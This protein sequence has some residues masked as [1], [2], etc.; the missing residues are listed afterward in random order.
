MTEDDIK[1]TWL[2]EQKKLKSQ[3]TSLLNES[4]IEPEPDDENNEDDD[5]K[6]G[7]TE[8]GDNSGDSNELHEHSDNQFGGSEV[9]AEPEKNS[10]TLDQFYIDQKQTSELDDSTETRVQTDIP[11]ITANGEPEV[12]PSNSNPEESEEL[13][14]S[15]PIDDNAQYESDTVSP[16]ELQPEQELGPQENIEPQDN[17]ESSMNQTTELIQEK[18]VEPEYDQIPEHSSEFVETSDQSDSAIEAT[19]VEGAEGASDVTD[20]QYTSD[21]ETS[22]EGF[23]ETSHDIEHAEV[24]TEL[25]TQDQ[26]MITETT[27]PDNHSAISEELHKEQEDH[28]AQVIQKEQDLEINQ[29]VVS[30]P[31]ICETEQTETYVNDSEENTVDLPDKQDSSNIEGPHN[32]DSEPTGI[33]TESNTKSDFKHDNESDISDNVGE[34][35]ESTT[36]ITP[37]ESNLVGISGQEDTN[38][39]PSAEPE[40]ETVQ[41]DVQ[42]DVQDI[43]PEE[44][45]VEE[46]EHQDAYII[47]DD[48]GPIA[49]IIQEPA[50]GQQEEVKVESNEN[51]EGSYSESATIEGMPVHETSLSGNIYD[52]HIDPSMEQQMEAS[53]QINDPQE[54]EPYY[55]APINTPT[56]DTGPQNSN[57]ELATDND[58]ELKDPETEN[59]EQTFEQASTPDL[60]T[61]NYPIEHVQEREHEHE[62]EQDQDQTHEVTI[63]NN[64]QDQM[65]YPEQTDNYSLE[66]VEQQELVEHQQPQEPQE[67][68]EQQ[69]PLGP[70]DQLDHHENLEQPEEQENQELQGFQEEQEQHEE[71]QEH[72]QFEHQELEQQ[73]PDL[74]ENTKTTQTEDQAPLPAQMDHIESS[75][76]T[77][78]HLHQNDQ[79]TETRQDFGQDDA[80]GAQTTPQISESSEISEVNPAISET[81]EGT[82]EIQIGT[83]TE[84]EIELGT[85]SEVGPEY[86]EYKVSE[87]QNQS[88]ILNESENSEYIEPNPDIEQGSIIDQTSDEIVDHVEIESTEPSIE[89]SNEHEN[90]ETEPSNVK[91]DVNEPVHSQD[92]ITDHQSPENLASRKQ[93]IQDIQEIQ[94]NQEIKK[95]QD[96]QTTADISLQEIES[97]EQPLE[98]A[99]VLPAPGDKVFD[100]PQKIE[101]MI[102]QGL[103]MI[104]KLPE[105]VDIAREKDMLIQAEDMLEKNDLQKAGEIAEECTK[106]INL[107]Y[108]QLLSALKILKGTQKKIQDAKTRGVDLPIAIKVFGQAKAALKDNDFKNT[109]AF[110]NL[111][112]KLLKKALEEQ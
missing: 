74:Q 13:E 86:E 91:V 56:M 22:S 2:E 53:T 79:E 1:A 88:E 59:A 38:N 80:H 71:Y 27:I 7:D 105:Y 23:N 24:N 77:S 111:I 67:L 97:S 32:N 11:V 98:N 99:E 106:Q 43:E 76:D 48:P 36:E 75:M 3:L 57:D 42:N 62:F 94:D 81:M 96:N 19:P 108:N 103:K 40:N 78:Q 44:S 112:D 47:S 82:D 89:V 69:E 102:S 50:F 46:P 107:V 64:D 51:S 20:N 6:K 92:P 9:H 95:I 26:E 63:P 16:T 8:K 52:G 104:E 35:V 30:E 65:D 93:E 83:E 90:V 28:I 109:V 14:Q 68:M 33:I 37:T 85:K 41:D 17:S 100:N 45:I 54:S 34:I 87:N 5:S 39:D 18:N 31:E 84:S 4:K 55:S 15:T 66:S 21:T 110:A 70:Q 58:E 25:E 73:V 72:E 60:G 49:P 101:M 10:T 61:D 29:E 12:D